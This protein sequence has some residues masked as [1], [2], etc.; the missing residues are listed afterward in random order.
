M[1]TSRHLD[2]GRSGEDRAASW[3]AG[4][5][6]RILERN[7][8]CP[9]GEIDLL[10]TRDDTLV[11]CEVKTRRSS[12]YGQP[13]EAVTVDKQRRLRRLAAYYLVSEG[14]HA[15]HRY[16]GEIRFDVASVLGATI[17]V[18]EGAF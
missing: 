6:F 14:D 2:V 12:A 4:R 13:F 3:Y 10:C 9:L 7:W 11:V 18:I 5:G 8:R 17:S 15:R 1:G 16:Y